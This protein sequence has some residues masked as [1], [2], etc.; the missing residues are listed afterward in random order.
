MFC[1]GIGGFDTGPGTKTLLP[2]ETTVKMDVRMVP[3]MD[4]DKVVQTIREHLERRGFG[5]IEMKVI[6]K[7]PWSKVSVKEPVVQALIKAYRELGAEPA[8]YPLNIGAAPFYL[9]DRVLGVP[10]VFG[11][12]GHGARQHSSNEYFSVQGLLDYEKSMVLT[13]ANYV[14]EMK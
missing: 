12:M 3:N 9:F 2:H 14:K 5:D 6:S 4:P 10:Y 1:F 11:G 8:V 7:Y 13:L